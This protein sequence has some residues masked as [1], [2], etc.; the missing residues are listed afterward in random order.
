M[1]EWEYA[2]ALALSM[3]GR[4]AVTRGAIDALDREQLGSVIDHELG[5]LAEPRHTRRVRL[6][7]LTVVIPFVALGPIVDTFGLWGLGLTFVGVILMS[8]IARRV[9]RSME[10]HANGHSEDPE[11]YTRALEAIYRANDAPGILGTGVHPNL[12]DRMI[13]AGVTPD[14]PRPLPPSRWRPRLAMVAA[15]LIA[16]FGIG[17]LRLIAYVVTSMAP[18]ASWAAALWGGV[19][20]G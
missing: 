14:W 17:F 9:G 19:Q 5:H 12:Y 15:L 3:A 11:V 13:A 2:N 4:V 6:A 16:G 20:P 8:G 10:E 1:I 18:E 7:R